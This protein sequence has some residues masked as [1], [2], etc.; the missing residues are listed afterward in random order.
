[1]NLKE[2]LYLFINYILFSNYKYISMS[3]LNSFIFYLV[4]YVCCLCDVELL[5]I[6]LIKC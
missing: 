2:N 3:D 5:F 4:R 6:V 1:M